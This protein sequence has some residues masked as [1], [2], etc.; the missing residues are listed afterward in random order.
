M[1]LTQNPLE[2]KDKG[3]EMP[4]TEEEKLAYIRKKNEDRL[5]RARMIQVI[6]EQKPL[7]EPEKK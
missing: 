7:N 2:V 6:P 5:S 1:N 3:S 4:I